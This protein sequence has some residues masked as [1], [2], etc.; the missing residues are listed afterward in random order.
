LI[1]RYV[2]A[3]K[4]GQD[5]AIILAIFFYFQQANGQTFYSAAVFEW[6]FGDDVAVNVVAILGTGSQNE[7]LRIGVG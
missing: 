5:S 7:A 6:F 4:G 2:L 1:Q 3:R